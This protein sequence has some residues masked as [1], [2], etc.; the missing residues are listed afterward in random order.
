MQA[1]FN[2]SGGR[3]LLG[4]LDVAFL[5]A[6]AV[7]MFCVGHLADRMHLRKFLT[8]GMLASAAAVCAFGMAQ[9]LEIHRLWYFVIIQIVGGV[10]H[11]ACCIAQHSVYYLLILSVKV[12]HLLCLVV[13]G[14]LCMTVE[15]YLHAREETAS[16][17]HA[18][19]LVHQLQARSMKASY[20]VQM[21]CKVIWC[22]VACRLHAGHWLA[23]RCCSDGQLV[24]QGKEGRCDG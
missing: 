21:T 20:A 14:W 7:G 18:S 2:A 13:M 10:Y 22:D 19:C 8:F 4:K 15:R 3:L 16:I 1:P 11:A 12:T 24:R 9:F 23:Q 5:G 17:F 6:Y